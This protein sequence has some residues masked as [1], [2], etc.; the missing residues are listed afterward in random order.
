[1]TE[2][3]NI[4]PNEEVKVTETVEPTP[5]PAPKPKKATKTGVVEGDRVRVKET[6]PTYKKLVGTVT[7]E[8]KGGNK[9]AVSLD[10]ARYPREVVFEQNELIKDG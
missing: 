9:V 3:E 1:M 2:E 4:Q 10:L 6:V 8:T 7:A 5:A